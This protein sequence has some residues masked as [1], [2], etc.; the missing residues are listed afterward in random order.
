MSMVKFILKILVLPIF[1]F[2]AIAQMI[3]AFFPEIASI[4][5]GILSTIFWGLA[6]A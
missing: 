2:V 3:G 1:I 6:I 4:I 5:L